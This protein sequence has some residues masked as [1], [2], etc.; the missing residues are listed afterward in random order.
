[1]RKIVVRK[2]IDTKPLIWG[3]SIPFFFL[4][5]A[6]AL[7]FLLFGSGLIIL[8]LKQMS[9]STAIGGV[10]VVLVGLPV[11]AILKGFLTKKSKPSKTNFGKTIRI[12]SNHDILK[13]L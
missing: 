9:G 7:G 6:V 8:G 5:V 10:A 2:G 1:M 13:Y 3:L 4:I 12:V 11:V